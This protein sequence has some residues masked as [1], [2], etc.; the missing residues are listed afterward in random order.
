MVGR[1]MACVFSLG[2][3]RDLLFSAGGGDDG[4]GCRDDD[5]RKNEKR[6]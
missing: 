5:G 4:G 1:R 3:K 2:Q 6:L